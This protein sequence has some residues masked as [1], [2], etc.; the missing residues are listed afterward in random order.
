MQDSGFFANSAGVTSVSWNQCIYEPPMLLVGCNDRMVLDASPKQPAPMEK[1]GPAEEL[2]QIWW[3]NEKLN[4]C[5]KVKVSLKEMLHARSI[6]DVAWAPH[7]G[8]SFHMLASASKDT[9]IVLWKL[10][11]DFN[12]EGGVE[13]MAMNYQSILQCDY[14][15]PTR[16]AKIVAVETVLERAG[17]DLGGQRRGQQGEGVPGQRRQPR[18]QG[19]R[20]HLSQITFSH[21]LSHSCFLHFPP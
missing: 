14:V 13:D 19:G 1:Q 20:R 3:L 18:A 2:L 12:K 17:V 16:H 4:R 9:K 5:E 11:I 15:V 8:R 10:T 6:T 7:V 21:V